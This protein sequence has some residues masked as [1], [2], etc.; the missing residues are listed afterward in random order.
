ML[1]I[2]YKIWVDLIY[3]VRTNPEQESMWKFYT[4]IF[5]SIAMAMNIFILRILV[6]QIV[7]IKL[8]DITI[9]I[10]HYDKINLFFNFFILYLLLPLLLN[11][12]LI[13]Y[14]NRYKTLIDM[15]NNYNGKLCKIYIFISLFSPFLIAILAAIFE[16]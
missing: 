16:K 2:Y 3:K 11:Y 4:I 7:G 6:E 10:F 12:F 1:K 15:Y 14:R 13:F 9:T 8:F 5:M